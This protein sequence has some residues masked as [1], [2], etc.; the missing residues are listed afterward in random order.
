MNLVWLTLIAI[1]LLVSVA[2][3]EDL[4]ATKQHTAT[5]HPDAPKKK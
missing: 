5:K 2:P 1:K 4:T 3:T